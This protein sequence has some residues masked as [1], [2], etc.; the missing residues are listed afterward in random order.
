MATKRKT[1]K[2]PPPVRTGGL[3]TVG[4]VLTELCRVYRAARR[5]E[6]ATDEATKLAH[7]L[8]EIRG[9][10]EGAESDARLRTL[11]ERVGVR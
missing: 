3:S 10:I 1:A 11:E 8:R 4:G 9:C 2:R 6:M 5:G 7:V